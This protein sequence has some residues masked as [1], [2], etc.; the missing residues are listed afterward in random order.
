MFQVIR[1]GGSIG[2]ASPVVVLETDDREAAKKYAMVSRRALT[3]GEK[4]YYGMTYKV[5]EVKQKVGS[6]K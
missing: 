4:H 3:K 6:L 5:K 2:Q 1:F